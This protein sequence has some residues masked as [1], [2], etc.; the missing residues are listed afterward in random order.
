MEET[1]NK[2]ETTY[3]SVAKFYGEPSAKPEDFFGTIFAFITAFKVI[4]FR[5]K[6]VLQAR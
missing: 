3:K 4:S 5:N 2:M 6:G 1:A